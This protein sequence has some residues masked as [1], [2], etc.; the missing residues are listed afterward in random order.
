MA[1]C[2]N[3]PPQFMTYPALVSAYMRNDP[4]AIK[5]LN[6]LDSLDHDW[7]DYHEW[8]L[9]M[10]AAV[11][12]KCWTLVRRSPL[13]RHYYVRYYYVDLAATFDLALTCMYAMSENPDVPELSSLFD[14]IIRQPD[15]GVFV[16]TRACCERRR[17]VMQYLERKCVGLTN[18]TA[19]AC[20]HM[21]WDK[22]KKAKNSKCLRRLWI[23]ACLVLT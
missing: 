19:A 11:R 6:S 7:A 3:T 23:T 1:C 16:M 14:E 12:L 2:W 9:L 22:P 8:A 20:Y 18:D 15:L 4:Q 17:G 21:R 13:M 10:T 5:Y